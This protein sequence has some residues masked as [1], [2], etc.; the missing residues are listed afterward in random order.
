MKKLSRRN[1]LL[2]VA[3]V[4]AGLAVA[5]AVNPLPEADAVVE[6]NLPEIEVEAVPFEMLTGLPTYKEE[7]WQYRI[8]RSQFPMVK[9]NIGAVYNC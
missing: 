4:G 9:H 6:V 5:A 2:K 1:F 7:V 3:G 8:R